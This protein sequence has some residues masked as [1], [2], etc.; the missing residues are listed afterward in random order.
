METKC[1]RKER[2]KKTYPK[3]RKNVGAILVKLCDRV[4]NVRHSLLYDSQLYKMYLNEHNHF[5]DNVV[6]TRFNKID[7]LCLELSLMFEEE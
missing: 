1:N 5:I 6:S 7:D 4:A 2:K 3:I